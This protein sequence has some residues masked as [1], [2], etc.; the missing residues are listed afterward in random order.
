MKKNQGRV[1]KPFPFPLNW[2]KKRLSELAILPRNQTYED[3]M[4]DTNKTTQTS[5]SGQKVDA[6]GHSDASRAGHQGDAAATTGATGAKPKAAPKPK[7]EKAE[8]EGRGCKS[9]YTGMILKTSLTTN[10]RREGTHGHK[11]L[12]I[13]LAAGAKGITYEDYL[14]KGGRLNDL[15]WDINKDNVTAEKPKA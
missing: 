3:K 8:G 6:T 15:N 13:I 5:A 9:Q 2:F 1:N 10:T 12:G 14:A 4:T 7:A 11:S